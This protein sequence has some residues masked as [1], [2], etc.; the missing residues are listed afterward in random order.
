MAINFDGI[1]VYADC[2]GNLHRTMNYAE[3]IQ[4]Q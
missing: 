2:S 3:V 1:F 4:Q